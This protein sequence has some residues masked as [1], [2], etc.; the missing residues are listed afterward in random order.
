MINT[1]VELNGEL[2]TSNI[3]NGEIITNNELNGE[4][5]NSVELNGEISTKTE[6]TG[7]LT[8]DVDLVGKVGSTV[9][10]SGSIA[11]TS[12]GTRNYDYLY[13]KPQI[14]SVELVK[15]KSF[16]DLGMNEITNTELNEMFRDL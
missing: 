5:I 10:L 3:L 15:N 12:D 16:E 9:E 6:L 14:N 11:T 7:E 1:Q 2:V 4:L 13:N 8:H